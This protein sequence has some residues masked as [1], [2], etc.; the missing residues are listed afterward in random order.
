MRTKLTDSGYIA[1]LREAIME[2][3]KETEEHCEG[4]A[5]DLSSV[6]N[7]AEYALG[8]EWEQ[9]FPNLNL[10]RSPIED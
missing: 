6:F 5:C 3:T 10:W 9:E 4:R 7:R 2:M 1:L 8:F